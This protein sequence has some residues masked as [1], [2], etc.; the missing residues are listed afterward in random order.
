MLDATANS[1]ARP[2]GFFDG[3]IDGDGNADTFSI[4]LQLI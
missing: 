2:T 3:G 1:D 4:A